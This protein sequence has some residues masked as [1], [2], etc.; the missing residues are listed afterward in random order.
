MV[1]RDDLIAYLLHRL[2]EEARGALAE[3]WFADPE[4]QEQLRLVEAELLD[5]YAR[6]QLTPEDRRAIET[7]LLHD[8]PV[9]RPAPWMVWA[10]AVAAVA[11]TIFVA[12]LV[13]ENVALRLQIGDVTI[14]APAAGSAPPPRVAAPIGQ[15]AGAIMAVPLRAADL[16]GGAGGSEPQVRLPAH[17]DVIRFDLELDPSDRADAYTI[18]LSRGEE[19][20]W[21]EEPVQRASNVAA[22]I[23]PFWVPSTRLTPGNYEIAVSAGGRALASF[24]FRLLVP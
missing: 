18:T 4:L 7:H 15:N 5:A 22:P 10:A 21:R 16:R 8:K 1:T 3:R 13:Q 2:P 11:L 23:L 6:G 19:V 14:T 24:R 9:R 12:W 20:I 17:A